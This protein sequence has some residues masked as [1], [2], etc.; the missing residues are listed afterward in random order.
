MHFIESP[1]EGSTP[2]PSANKRDFTFI[3]IKKL[4]MKKLT[5]KQWFGVT[6]VLAFASAISFFN[7]GS[8]WADDHN[9]NGLIGFTGTGILGAVLAVY[10]LYKSTK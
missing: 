9:F 4:N 3:K 2:S 6:A 8:S 1:L 10:A 5:Q 7:I